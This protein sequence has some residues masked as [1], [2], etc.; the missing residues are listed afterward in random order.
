[1]KLSVITEASSWYILLCIVVAAVYAGVL[2]FREAKLKDVSKWLRGI[3]T[4]FRFIV[5]FFLA[6][7]LMSPLLKTIFREV[8]KPVIVIAQDESESLLMGKDSSFNKNEYPKKVQ[9]L[10]DALS[11]KFNVVTYS[12]GDKFREKTEFGYKD[13]LTDFSTLFSELETRYADRNLGAVI[14]ASYVIYNQG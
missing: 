12:F 11:D 9:A 6:F 10:I 4:V 1:M 13:K 2:Y 5:V 8:E 3:M 7:L 14:I